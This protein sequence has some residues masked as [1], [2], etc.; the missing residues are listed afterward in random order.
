MAFCHLLSCES[1][2]IMKKSNMAV[3]VPTSLM[4]L[5][6]LDV[7]KL[8]RGLQFLHVLL[9]PLRMREKDARIRCEER[10]IEASRM[11]YPCSLKC[12]FKAT[13]IN[14]DCSQLDCPTALQGSAVMLFFFWF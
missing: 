12:H 2:G 11:E 3:T 1:M 9:H 14:D 4:D 8:A 13:S 5:R 7:K 6:R 10:G